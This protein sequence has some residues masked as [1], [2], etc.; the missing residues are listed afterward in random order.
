ML[1]YTTSACPMRGNTASEIHGLREA[2]SPGDLE[3]SRGNKACVRATRAPGGDRHRNRVCVKSIV[4]CQRYPLQHRRRQIRATGGDAAWI[5]KPSDSE[6]AQP[7]SIER[8][9]TTLP[10][11]QRSRNKSNGSEYI[12]RYTSFLLIAGQVEHAC[13]R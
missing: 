2:V 3:R 13:C 10:H 11:I 9:P 6:T 1:R 12:S 7:E 8:Q 4:A 5:R